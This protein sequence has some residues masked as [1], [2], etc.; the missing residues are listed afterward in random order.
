MNTPEIKSDTFSTF[1][2]EV[3]RLL[4]EMLVVH[5][6]LIKHLQKKNANSTNQILF[7]DI[8][9]NYVN[10]M[11][12]LALD[13]FS[14]LEYENNLI[15]FCDIVI[16][17]HIEEH[18]FTFK[19]YFEVLCNVISV[20]GF[21]SISKLIEIPQ[22]LYKLRSD[23][24]T[25][26]DKN[27]EELLV[28]M[29]LL[30]PIEILPKLINFLNDINIEEKLDETISK[31]SDFVSGNHIKLQEAEKTKEFWLN[32]GKNI[33]FLKEPNR[34]LICDSRTHPMSFLNASRFSSHFFILFN[35]IFVH[36]IGSSSYVHNLTTIWVEPQQDESSHLYQLILKMPEET[37]IL[38]TPEPEI[39]IDW[40]H[41]MQTAIKNALNRSNSLQPPN[42]RNGSFTFTKSGF[43]KDATYT[44]RWLNAK[45]QGKGKLEW[46]DGKVYTGQF[47][48]NQLCGFGTMYNPSEGTYEG[49]WRE[50]QQNGYG[51]LTY[52]NT[53]IYKGHFKDGLPYGHGF[54]RKGNFMANSASFYIGDWISGAKNGY[55]VLDDIV[56]GEKYIGN[57][58]DNK[59]QG[60]GLI[61]TSDGVYYE[62]TFS[63][64][65]LIGHGIMVLEDGTHYEGELKGTGILN[66]KGT[67]TLPTGD[68][69]EGSLCG[70]LEE[71]IKISNGVFTKSYN[72]KKLPKSFG[73]LCTQVDQKWKALF[74]YFYQTLGI[75]E[76]NKNGLK[77][78]AHRI[79]QN[80]AVV[81][82]NATNLT[83]DKSGDN[84]LPS[85]LTNLDII[86]PFGRENL[87]VTTYHEVQLYLSK[88][89]DSSFHP[90][91]ALLSNISEAYT[92]TY[93]GRAHTLL[94]DHAINELHYIT[95]K[96]YEI[97]RH[98]FPALPAHDT[99]ISIESE[100][101]EDLI[102]YHSLLYPMILPKFHPPLFTL[103]TLKNEQF[104]K[105]Y[106][107][108]IMEWNKQS[109]VALMAYLSVHPKFYK[110]E[111]DLEGVPAKNH[112]F[113]EAIENL[114]QLK[115][116][117]SPTEKLLVIREAVGKLTPV[118]QQI[119]GAN[120]IWNM[121]D[122]FPVFLY[123]VV[124]SRIS[125]LGSE[126]DF[127]DNFMDPN[128]ESGE[129]GIMFTTLKACYQ[130]ILQE[131]S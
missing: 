57:W 107:K 108:T 53:D 74:K 54:L 104:E 43:L 16:V 95:K 27:N 115:S 9:K 60:N 62:G 112:I 118:V 38:C 47:N 94:L 17:K 110:T 124:R 126:L 14:L 7:E 87:D 52:E 6:N 103:F 24:V 61:I 113:F 2:I 78:D 23:L 42:A 44:G 106:K 35:D 65:L 128:L 33:D 46:P 21:N 76:A 41:A 73:Q 25:K 48:N 63:Q 122:L 92:T 83:R 119:L 59:K 101:G 84:K 19:E 45:M 55:G 97:I 121:D 28:S 85:S 70:S 5:V 32:F 102:S 56:T 40:F 129:L 34:R 80:V 120:Y 13:I 22:S 96:L 72:Q 109:D 89:F 79:W 20:D 98:L 3:Q 12:V 50:N 1:L 100:M 77:L 86:P 26:K 130:Q 88:A 81:L 36:M 68:F 67:L 123:V 125:D 90:L 66:G 29:F 71:G 99:E 116:T 10:F 69:I 8:C 4:E 58:S 64:D 37:I 117:F 15:P 11:H 105:Q 75:P 39:K 131:K 31:I 51:T 127:M 91:G 111:K 49:Q 18:L 114:Q 30:S 82:S 93:G